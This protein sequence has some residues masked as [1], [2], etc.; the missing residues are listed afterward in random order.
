M[1]PE[2]TDRL[3]KRAADNIAAALGARERGRPELAVG[4]IHCARDIL[5]AVADAHG[6]P[7]QP[8]P[9]TRTITITS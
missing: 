5:S 7:S 1:T 9:A 3:L 6:M 8:Q 2:A 4:N